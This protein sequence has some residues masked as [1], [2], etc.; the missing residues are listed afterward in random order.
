MSAERT[1]RYE[2]QT[3][4]RL[5]QTNTLYLENKTRNTEGTNIWIKKTR[6]IIEHTEIQK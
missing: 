6:N 5:T 1:F 3:H 4:R 2:E